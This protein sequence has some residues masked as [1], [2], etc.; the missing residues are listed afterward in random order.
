MLVLLFF[1][2]GGIIGWL[3]NRH[4]LET[5]PTFMH[6]EFITSPTFMHPEFMDENGNIIPDEILAVRFENYDY[7]DDNE[8]EDD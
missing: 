5:S 8:E 1:T 7:D 6:P 3:A 4:F 2:V